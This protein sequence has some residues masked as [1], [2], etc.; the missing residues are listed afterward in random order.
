MEIGRRLFWMEGKH[1]CSSLGERAWLMAFWQYEIQEKRF[2][3]QMP[4]LKIH[5]VS[6]SKSYHHD[7]R[8]KS[9]IFLLLIQP[10]QHSYDQCLQ[11]CIFFCHLTFNPSV[12]FDLKYI[13][14][15]QQM[16]LA[17]KI[18]SDNLCFLIGVFSQLTF[19]ITVDMV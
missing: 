1:E 16:D 4:T 7:F 12:S 13:C 17:F 6:I 18:L 15:A 11:W 10:L 2:H 8:S 9:S 19:N 14:Y 3:D 5:C